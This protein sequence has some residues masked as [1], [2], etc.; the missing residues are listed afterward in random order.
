MIR[1]ALDRTFEYYDRE[2]NAQSIEVRI[3]FIFRP[4]CE[5]QTY[6]P[7]ERC[8]PAEPAEWEFDYAEREGGGR[9]LVGEWLEDWCRDVLEHTEESA[10]TDA[11]PGCGMD[12]DDRRDERIDRELT[13]RAALEAR[14]H[15]MRPDGSYFKSGS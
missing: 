13:E 4:G 7:A 14:G 3:H 15:R 6:G 1:G 10:L 11:L 12:Q 2:Q 5:A 9:L 8:Y